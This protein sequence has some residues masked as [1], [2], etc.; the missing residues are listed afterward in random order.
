MKQ[1]FPKLENQHIWMP[2]SKK[3]LFLTGIAAK[4]TPI[5]IRYVW[6]DEY[7]KW[8]R[9]DYFKYDSMARLRAIEVILEQGGFKKETTIKQR[10][11][12]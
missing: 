6:S 1:H 3:V 11:A 2:P 5:A 9:T 10:G 4:K 8:R 12:A 7:S